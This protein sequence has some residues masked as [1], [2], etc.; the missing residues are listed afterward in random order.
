MLRTGD[1]FEDLASG[2][3]P[4]EG[5]WAGVMV[6]EIVHDGGFEI[7][8]ALE[9]AAP[10]TLAGDLGEEA[11]DHVE[12]RRGGRNE[13]QVEAWMAL[14]PAR[15]GRCLMGGV[16]VEDEVQVELCRGLAAVAPSAI[17]S[18]RAIHA[19]SHKRQML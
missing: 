15:H 7:G 17:A 10:D 14:E 3:C 6:V 8:D 5:F 9:D 2:L 11:L 1:L 19:D 13:V 4:D 16:V 18:L 12:P